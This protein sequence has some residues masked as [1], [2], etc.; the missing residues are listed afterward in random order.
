MTEESP[1]PRREPAADVDGG[2]PTPDGPNDRP[3]GSDPFTGDPSGLD[4][5]ELEIEA[6]LN[7]PVPPEVGVEPES[8]GEGAPGRLGGPSFPGAPS[9]AP[10][11]SPSPAPSLLPPPPGPPAPPLQEGPRPRGT[12]APSETERLLRAEILQLHVALETIQ[13]DVAAHRSAVAGVHGQLQQVHNVLSEMQVTNMINNIRTSGERA[14]AARSEEVARPPTTGTP[15]TLTAAPVF[16]LGP[17]GQRVHAQAFFTL[18]K[19]GAL[20]SFLTDVLQQW[21]TS[22]YPI[23]AKGGVDGFSLTLLEDPEGR[24]LRLLPS[25]MY[26][27]RL[28]HREL[29]ALDQLPPLVSS[30]S[31]T[32]SGGFMR[33]SP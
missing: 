31:W 23:Q 14:S 25:G 13:R 24:G 20:E 5:L 22:G 28:G 11:P 16:F 10:V 6:I 19:G 29:E 2:T 26:L 1:S 32:R 33:P 9:P 18:G 4:E 7:A 8:G 27:M 17:D 30:K 15:R 12:T 3:E 21:E